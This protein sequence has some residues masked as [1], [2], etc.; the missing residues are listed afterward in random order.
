MSSAFAKASADDHNF[1]QSLRSWEIMSQYQVPQ[2]IDTETKIVG[3]LTLKQFLYI[4]V[5]SLISFFL[6]FILQIWL[7]FIITAILG[8]AAAA[9]AFIKFNGRPLP[10]IVIS[11]V[12]YFWK[13]R[14]YLWQREEVSPKLTG[15]RLPKTGQIG[16]AEGGSALKNLWNKL[17]TTTTGIGKREK[18]SP[19]AIKQVRQQNQD[20]GSNQ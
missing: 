7:W 15:I 1:S 8:V 19:I 14:M 18:A 17:L 20:S 6:F 3:P 2:F 12:T 13:P 11:M 16:S 4:G 10:V 5:A 9:L